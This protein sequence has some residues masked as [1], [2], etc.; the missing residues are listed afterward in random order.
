LLFQLVSDL[1]LASVK[2]L[3]GSSFSLQYT[4]TCLNDAIY[5][6]RGV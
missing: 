6:N 4:A 2:Y 5:T 3:C 1:V